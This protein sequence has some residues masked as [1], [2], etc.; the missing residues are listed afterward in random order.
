MT[1]ELIKETSEL[2]EVAGVLP[3]KDDDAVAD[4]DQHIDRI[5]ASLNPSQK[6]I[7]EL[8]E[9]THSQSSS[10]LWHAKHVGRIIGRNR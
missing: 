3:A 7:A 9:A 10:D 8:E 4:I 5:A 2:F 6:A 1:E